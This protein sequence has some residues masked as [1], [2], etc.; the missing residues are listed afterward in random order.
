MRVGEIVR[1][2]RPK[3]DADMQTLEDVAVLVFLSYELDAFLAKYPYE[4]AKL[5]EILAKAWRKM[6]TRGHEAALALNPPKAVVDLLRQGLEAL[7]S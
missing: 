1:K 4:P 5:A 7:T 2:D 3:Q 6:S